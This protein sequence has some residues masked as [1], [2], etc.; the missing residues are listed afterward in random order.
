MRYAA[1]DFYPSPV[2]L[3]F[4]MVRCTSDFARR[5]R[6]DMKRSSTTLFSNKPVASPDLGLQEMQAELQ[7]LEDRDWWLWGM[8]VIVMLLLTFAVFTMSFPGLI[9]VDDPF[10]DASLNRAVRG[11]VGL[12][13]IFNAYTIHQ[14]I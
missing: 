1:R 8:A 14:Q 7:R 5:P 9:K 12:V 4:M 6:L 13:L 3:A 11:L 10:F 2:S